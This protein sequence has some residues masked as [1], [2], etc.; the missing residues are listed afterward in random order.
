MFNQSG[1]RVCEVLW[2]TAELV[3]SFSH[4]M[5][6]HCLRETHHGGCNANSTVIWVILF[7][8]W[9]AGFLCVFNEKGLEAISPRKD[10]IQKRTWQCSRSFCCI[11]FG[12]TSWKVGSSCCWSHSKG[13][14]PLCVVCSR[15]RRNVYRRSANSEFWQKDIHLFKEASRYL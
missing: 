15:K 4:A 14:K 13:I 5:G 11:R 3:G 1:P 7:H 12:N 8:N 10:Y 2:P 6:L 9:I